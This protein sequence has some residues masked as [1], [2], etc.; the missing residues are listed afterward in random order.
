MGRIVQVV[1]AAPRWSLV[2]AADEPPGVTLLPI[3]A[4]ALVEG[5]D[6]SREVLPMVSGGA[7]AALRIAG[8]NGDRILGVLD[9]ST[10][11]RAALVRWRSGAAPCVEVPSTVYFDPEAA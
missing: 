3:A 5:E 11:G 7:G 6:G 2:V 4:W 10:D 8:S 9:P 1:A